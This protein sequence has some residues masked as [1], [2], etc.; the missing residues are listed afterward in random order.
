MRP[1]RQFTVT[2]E[3]EQTRRRRLK[4]AAAVRLARRRALRDLDW[5]QVS[6]CGV[7]GLAEPHEC[8]DAVEVRPL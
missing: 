4:E 7:C 2:D 5:Q 6:R 3:H 8:L 1:D